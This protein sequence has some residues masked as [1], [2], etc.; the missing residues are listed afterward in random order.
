MTL[1]ELQQENQRRL[2]LERQRETY[3]PLRGIGCSGERRLVDTPVPDLPSA[4]VPVEMLDDSAY[5]AAQTNSLQWQLLRCRHDFEYWCVRC[6]VVKHKLTGQ[7]IPFVLNRPQRRV[8]AVME[9]MRRRQ[10]PIR[11]ILLKARQWGGS[12]VV[13]MYMAWIQSCHA[14]NWHSLICAHVKDTAAGIRGMY[15][16][17][18]G[19]YPSE[20]WD[21]DAKPE[22]KSF[23]GCLNIREIRGRGCRVTI[24]S[25]ENQEA[26]RGSDFAMAHLSEVAFYSK[27]E[28]RSPVA[29]VRAV[30]GAIAVHPLTLI[31][32]ESTANGVGNYFHSE[33]LRSVEGKGDKQ[34]VFVPWYEIEIYSMRCDDPMALYG[35]L[36]EYEQMLWTELQ[37]PLERIAWYR[38]KSSEYAER[39]QMQAEYPT[40]AEEAFINSGNNVFD[41]SAVERLR[42]QCRPAEVGDL[43]HD[44]LEFVES[45]KG[46][47]Q[48]WERPQPGR[49]YVAA[50]DVGGRWRGA[51]WS[52]VTVLKH[53]GNGGGHEVVAQWR[54]HVDHDVLAAVSMDIGR[55]YRNAFLV[56]ESNTLE[57]NCH[58]NMFV[59][60]R[61]KDAYPNMYMRQASSFD[62]PEGGGQR[63]GF[64]TNRSTKAMLISQLIEAV[65]D[66]MYIERDQNACN[67]YLTYEQRQDGS[68][69]AKAGYHDD[70][71]MTRAMAVW[72]AAHLP[73][74]VA[75]PTDPRFRRSKAKEFYW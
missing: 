75:E 58:D 50:V 31:V 39:E 16:K 61:M 7:D 17:L 42:Q 14:R 65:R 41:V 35:S 26:V 5:T 47:L 56:I 63:I 36:N 11:M 64:H 46:R 9:G 55:W 60:E 57:S 34:P 52:V 3:D 66:G 32:M 22:L 20:L 62:S 23:E 73:A 40:T 70:I 38:A 30:C 67:E 10:A 28:A 71:L 74:Y 4:W 8:A 12:T 37:L 6:A 54:G 13:Q 18:I 2:D 1:H 29:F 48:L 69:G 33:W 19:S 72:A 45:P 68:Y 43:R 53:G 59:L 21:G 49:Q 27:G 51:D 15:N 25:S 24:G 44:D